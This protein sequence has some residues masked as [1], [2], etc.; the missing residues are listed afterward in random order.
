MFPPINSLNID[1]GGISSSISASS[2][3]LRN[4]TIFFVSHNMGDVADF[5]DHVLVLDNGHLVMDGTPRE[6]FSR[7]EQLREIGLGLP[8]AM[9]FG[10]RFGLNALTVDELVSQLYGKLTQRE[11]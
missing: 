1:V 4:L 5:A 9:E 10:N 7:G 2:I 11:G 8:P 3:Y 6:V